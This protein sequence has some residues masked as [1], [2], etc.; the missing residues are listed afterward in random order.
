MSFVIQ[1][2]TLIIT[3]PKLVKVPNYAFI[4]GQ[5]IET[6]LL[7]KQSKLDWTK[8]FELLTNHKIHPCSK[9]LCY[10]KFSQSPRRKEFFE[11]LKAIGY[12][13]VLSN[14]CG[15]GKINVDADIIVDSLSK[16]YEISE[17]NLVL[18]SGDG[19]FVP[20]LKNF[21][22]LNRSVWI[23]GGSEVNISEN[24]KTKYSYR[25]KNTGKKVKKLR[26]FGAIFENYKEL[27]S[28]LSVDELRGIVGDNDFILIREKLRKKIPPFGG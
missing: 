23:I 22:R 25:D 16:Y 3:Q 17:F 19:D 20:L 6:S 4:D 13:V 8:L 2:E 7:W 14:F 11:Q 1:S 21:E 24:L 15:N 26:S 28:V 27:Y 9:I 10:F 12:Q 18:L 5:N